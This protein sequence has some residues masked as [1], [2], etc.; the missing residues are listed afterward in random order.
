MLQAKRPRL[1]AITRCVAAAAAA[2]TAHAVVSFKCHTS[3][4]RERAAQIPRRALA[5]CMRQESSWISMFL[6]LPKCREVPDC[7]VSAILRENA[8]LR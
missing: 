2:P 3:A 6:F 1:E 7:D 8:E 4:Q 5:E